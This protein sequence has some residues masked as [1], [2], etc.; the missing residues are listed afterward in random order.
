MKTFVMTCTCGHKMKV[1]ADDRAAAVAMM[2]AQMT[3]QAL[4]DHIKQLHKPEEAMPTL[5]Q[6]HMM[7]EQTLQEETPMA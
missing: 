4:E 6:A 7:I 5:E 3:Q 2:K 1:Q